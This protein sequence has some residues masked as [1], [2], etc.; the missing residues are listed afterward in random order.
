M[1]PAIL[2]ANPNGR[3]NSDVLKPWANGMDLTRHSAGKW[4]IDFGLSMNET[5]AAFYEAPFTYVTEHVKPTRQRNRIEKLRSYWWRHENSRPQMWQALQGLPR[6]I[7]TPR[8]AK[9]L[10]R[11]GFFG[12]SIP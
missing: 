11:P 6:Y 4:I 5:D 1:F 9:H 7:A 12:G 3:S 10:N 2:P 8:V